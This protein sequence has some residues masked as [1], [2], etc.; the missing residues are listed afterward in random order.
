METLNCSQSRVQLRI[1][2]SKV[3]ASSL[4]T[5]RPWASVPDE[6]AKGLELIIPLTCDNSRNGPPSN[7][8]TLQITRAPLARISEQNGYG[9]H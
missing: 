3:G 1:F 4:G 8:N 5:F 2:P 7:E 6:K 9:N